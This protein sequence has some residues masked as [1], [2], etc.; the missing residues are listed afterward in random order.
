MGIPP[1]WQPVVL[2]KGGSGHIPIEAHRFVSNTVYNN[3][4]AIR[5]PDSIWPKNELSSQN[6]Y[7][8][9]LDS[10]DIYL[11]VSARW[12]GHPYDAPKLVELQSLDRDRRCGVT[13]ISLLTLND[14]PG[15]RWKGFGRNCRRFIAFAIWFGYVVLN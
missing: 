11:H 5:Y 13:T 1:H 6:P 9:R 3:C 15:S 14:Q 2:S 10:F 12:D 4:H 8:V 7:I